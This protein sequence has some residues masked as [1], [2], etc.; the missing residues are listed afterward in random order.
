MEMVGGTI[1]C[2]GPAGAK[3]HGAQAWRA[4]PRLLF[5]QCPVT[6]DPPPFLAI[7]STCVFP[8]ESRTTDRGQA[9][10]ISVSPARSVCLARGWD[11]LL[12][13]DQVTLGSR[14]DLVTVWTHPQ[15]LPAFWQIVAIH[16][17]DWVREDRSPQ[18]LPLYC[19]T[20][21]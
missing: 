16:K 14:P 6:P 9:P 18:L 1:S 8:T 2:R 21:L 20:K 15:P 10:L 3:W 13:A 7:H 11:T 17:E 5:S 19:K 4:R 12:H